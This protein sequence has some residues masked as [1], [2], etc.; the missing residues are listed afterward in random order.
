ML[1]RQLANSTHASIS[2]CHC[3]LKI[4]KAAEFSCRKNL[5]HRQ[6]SIRT[7]AIGKLA[8]GG[9]R[10][11]CCSERLTIRHSY[12]GSWSSS[13][14]HANRCKPQGHQ[15]SAVT[16]DA[17]WVAGLPGKDLPMDV[18]WHVFQVGFH[19]VVTQQDTN[20]SASQ[21]GRLRRPFLGPL[22]QKH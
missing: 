20:L 15:V 11:T 4:Q 1:C 16:A 3:Y 7:S 2:S 5:A 12:R 21:S 8:R 19:L 13:F 18:T 9:L 17:N 10:R 22:S 6:R 14:L